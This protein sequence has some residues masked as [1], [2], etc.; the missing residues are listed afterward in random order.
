[1][2]GASAAPIH[3]GLVLGGFRL[4]E[5]IGADGLGELYR[6]QDLHAQA[7]ALRVIHAD[8]LAQPGFRQQLLQTIKL[9]DEA[10]HPN[11]LRFYDHGEDHGRFYIVQELLSGQTL[12]TLTAARPAE[13]PVSTVAEWIYQALCGLGHAHRHGIVHQVLLML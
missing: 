8:L 9:L 11:L 13:Q 10:I 2:T 3:T 7:R 6:A 1:M 12:R 4:I 5:Q